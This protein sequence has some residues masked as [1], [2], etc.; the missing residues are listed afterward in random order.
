MNWFALCDGHGLREC[1]TCR[2]NAANQPLD[3]VG[4]HQAWMLAQVRNGSCDDYLPD[5]N[6]DAEGKL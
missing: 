5:P 3:A 1:D 4:E 2:R 6:R